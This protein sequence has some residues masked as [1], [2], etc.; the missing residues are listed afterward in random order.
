VGFLPLF[1]I[2]VLIVAGLVN[3][4]LWSLSATTLHVSIRVQLNSILFAKTLVRKDVASSSGSSENK[5][6]NYDN[7]D[8]ASESSKKE[9]EDDFTSKAQVMT[10]MTTDVDR[11]SEFG[12]H[13]FTLVGASL[14]LPFIGRLHSQYQRFPDRNHH[15]HDFPVRIAGLICFH[16]TR[17][18]LLVPTLE[19]SGRED[20]CWCTG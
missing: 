1:R 15:W 18:D 8:A 14:Y 7:P 9:D 5:T 20:H 17:G 12:W 3:G 16:R 10:L 19:P 11:V 13:V 2:L 4:Q 6:N